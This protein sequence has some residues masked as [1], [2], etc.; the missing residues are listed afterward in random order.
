MRTYRY[1]VQ[2]R[3]RDT[4]CLGH[5]NNVVYLTYIESCRTRFCQEKL[6]ISVE[7]GKFPL[8]LARAEIDF[9]A[10]GY[11]DYSIHVEASIG[12]IGSKSFQQRYQVKTDDG[13]LLARSEAV[14]VWYDFTQETSVLIPDSVKDLLRPYQSK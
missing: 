12:R 4:D 10:Q 2:V 13:L 7:G 8:I 9:V 5:I 14:I 3:F 1:D 11:F 6:G